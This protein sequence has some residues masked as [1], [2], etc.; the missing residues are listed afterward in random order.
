MTANINL[1]FVTE[2]RCITL[3]QS[4]V[5]AAE[6]NLRTF[7]LIRGLVLPSRQFASIRG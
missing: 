1:E 4:A 7:A 2:L 5:S 3:A 6:L